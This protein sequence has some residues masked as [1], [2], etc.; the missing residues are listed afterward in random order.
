MKEGGSLEYLELG[1]LLH[2]LIYLGSNTITDKGAEYIAEAMH[3]CPKLKNIHFLN[4]LGKITYQNFSY[5]LSMYSLPAP[6]IALPYPTVGILE[7]EIFR[8]IV[9]QRLNKPESFGTN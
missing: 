5:Y 2:K 8:L 7:Y 1:I 9:N 6:Q 4:Q 3:Y